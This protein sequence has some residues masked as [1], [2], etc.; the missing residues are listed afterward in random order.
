[1]DFVEEASLKTHL[2]RFPRLLILRSFTK[3]F[4]IP[5]MRLGC[6]LGAPELMARLAAVQ[7]P[8]SV[9]TMAQAMGRACLAGPRL[10][11]RTRALIRREREYLL[12]RLA[13]LP[14]LTAVSQRGE[15]SPGENHP[16]GDDRG[17]HCGSRCW[18]TAS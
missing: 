13:A 9:N 5:G 7:E 14:G 17:Q 8:W 4:A 18:P 6:L 15:L 2:G 12:E 11:G 10:Y 1:M 3:F 16:A